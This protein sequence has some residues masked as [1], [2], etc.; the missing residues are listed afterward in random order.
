M[1][2]VGVVVL[3]ASYV[4]FRGCSRVR[5]VEPAPSPALRVMTFNLDVD[6]PERESALKAIEEAGAD[7]VCLQE[8]SPDWERALAARFRARYPEMRFVRAPN[9]YGGAAILS[10]FPVHR[11]AEIPIAP[12]GWF[13]SQ[14]AVV[15]TPLGLVQVLNVHLRP[16]ATDGGNKVIGVFTSGGPRK[17]EVAEILS[18]LE[19]GVATIVA[20]DFNEGD[21]GGAVGVVRGRGLADCLSQFDKHTQTW[22]MRGGGL[23]RLA[24]RAD[25]VLTSKELHCTEARVIQEASSDH[26][27]VVAVLGRAR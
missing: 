1:R 8:V 4:A 6:A 3:L 15:E 7:V 17:R 2:A 10:R 5:P 19:P 13:P 14:W 25:H 26:D 24:E 21:G 12:G 27:P 9:P 18:K 11:H 23:I 20:G 22:R 16:P